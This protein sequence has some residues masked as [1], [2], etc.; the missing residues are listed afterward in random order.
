[1]DESVCNK[2]KVDSIGLKLKSGK[3]WMK[4]DKN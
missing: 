3:K 4:M 1:M 2:M